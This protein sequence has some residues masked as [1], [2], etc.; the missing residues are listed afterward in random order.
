MRTCREFCFY[1]IALFLASYSVEILLT[2]FFILYYFSQ[3]LT[4]PKKVRANASKSAGKPAASQV[5]AAAVDSSSGVE[6]VEV[7]DNRCSIL[8]FLFKKFL[9]FIPTSDRLSFHQRWRSLQE[10]HG[11]C[12]CRRRQLIWHRSSCQRVGSFWLASYTLPCPLTLLSFCVFRTINVNKA[13]RKGRR[14]ATAVARTTT[15]VGSPA[16]V[17]KKEK[18]LLPALDVQQHS[19]SEAQS[20]DYGHGA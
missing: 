14:S 2:L 7:V 8:F 13:S 17:V 11:L 12:Y 19:S 4:P 20:T 6:V 5:S 3:Q 1:F 10:E 16:I 18:G 15:N 9:S